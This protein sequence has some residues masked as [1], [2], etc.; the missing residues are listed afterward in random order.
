VID[1]FQT[2]GHPPPI[3]FSPPPPH[4]S[5]FNNTD[6][7]ND[8]NRQQH[9][10]NDN[11]TASTASPSNNNNN[12]DTAT[13]TSI[14]GMALKIRSTTFDNDTFDLAGVTETTIQQIIQDAFT[15][16]LDVRYNA[17]TM[18]SFVLSLLCVVVILLLLLFFVFAGS[19]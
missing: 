10:T 19:C 6:N 2:E 14:H 1:S 9:T 18:S 16:P 3:S 12:T 13:T 15:Q 11:M 4:T 8:D 7:D 5:L 17:F